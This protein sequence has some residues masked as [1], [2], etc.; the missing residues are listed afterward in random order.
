MLQNKNVKQINLV[1]FCEQ[2]KFKMIYLIF[3]GKRRK[4]KKQGKI[5][6]NSLFL[7]TKM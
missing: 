6:K 5:I 4:N 2:N 7:N 3:R 1:I